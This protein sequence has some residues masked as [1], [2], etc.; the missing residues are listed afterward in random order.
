MARTQK[1]R[2]TAATAPGTAAQT[3]AQKITAS[4][5]SQPLQF[6]V[7]VLETARP[8]ADLFTAV[9]AHGFRGVSDD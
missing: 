2:A 9:V 3:S 4:T 8:G 6:L 1:S 7:P 5:V